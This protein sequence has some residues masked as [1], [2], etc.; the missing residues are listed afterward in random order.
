MPPLREGE[1]RG[2]LAS[3]DRVHAC[4]LHCD[5]GHDPCGK[6]WASLPLRCPPP[7][8]PSPSAVRSSYAT[9]A[10]ASCKN[11]LSDSPVATC[12]TAIHQQQQRVYDQAGQPWQEVGRFLGQAVQMGRLCLDANSLN[13]GGT[14]QSNTKYERPNNRRG[15]ARVPVLQLTWRTRGLGNE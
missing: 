6:K 4:S 15:N 11:W 7:P 1:Q 9:A 12:I 13:L 14:N 8:P 3:G 5:C 10:A 2:R